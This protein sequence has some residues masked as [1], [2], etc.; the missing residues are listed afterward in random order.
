MQSSNPILKDNLFVKESAFTT[1]E[2]MTLRGTVNK[3]FSLVGIC[4]LTSVLTWG[5]LMGLV[6]EKAG[7]ATGV[8][9]GSA[10]LGFIV[11]MVTIFKHSWAPVTAPLY[12]ALEGVVLGAVS[13]M[14]EQRYPGIVF[15]AV[16]LTFGVLFSL[17][18][19]YKSGWIRASEKFKLGIM[20]ATGA[21][22]IIYLIGFVMS[23]F[24]TRIP[25]I[26]EATPIGIGFSLVVVVI[27]SLNF[28]LDFD[29]IE[30]GVSARAPRYMEWYSGFAILITL[31]WLYME[32]LKL[33]GKVRDRR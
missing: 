18:F 5:S 30:R 15:Q 3:T 1:N 4:F 12:A 16:L 2:V 8:L 20:A 26:H 19:A 24:G 10:I 11:A 27:A 17:L 33:L 31:V 23:F 32:I 25:M 14:F 21:V 7:S 22:A 29:M 6:P 28:I 13:L 9:I